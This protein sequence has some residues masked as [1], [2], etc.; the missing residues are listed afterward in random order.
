MS[1]QLIE[2]FSSKLGS[3]AMDE[4]YSSTEAVGAAPVDILA[5][6]E[7][8]L[9]SQSLRLSERNRRFL[10][11]VVMQTVE[12]HA[13][14][15][16]AYSIGVDVFGRDDNFDPA[17]DPIVR[18]E[19]NRLR[20]ALAAYYDGPGRADN[21]VIAIP[22]G[23]YV[24]SFHSRCGSADVP[25]YLESEASRPAVLEATIVIHDRSGK[26]DPETELRAELF[27]DSLLGALQAVRFK[28]R[29][30]PGRERKAA[31]QA[32]DELFAAPGNAHSLDIAVRSLGETRRFSW[33]LIDLRSGEVVASEFREFVSRATP[34][35][36]LIDEFAAAVAAKLAA[37]IGKGAASGL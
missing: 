23:S 9:A 11:F 30:V 32:I 14:R 24:P 35:F 16:K 22:K 19:A 28:V 31:A 34:C 13:E 4:I 17:V 8:M 36:G 2:R 29:M 10:S 37:L 26:S 21:V 18:I 5:A 25:G 3:G 1:C 27:V 7:G 15:I 33:R 12:G 20:N 6:L